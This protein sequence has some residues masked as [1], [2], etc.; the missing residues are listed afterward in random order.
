MYLSLIFHYLAPFNKMKLNNN[1]KFT[2]NDKIAP[3]LC[4]TKTIHLC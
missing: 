2:L 3:F 4:K 1:I